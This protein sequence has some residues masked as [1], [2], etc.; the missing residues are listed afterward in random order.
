MHGVQVLACVLIDEQRTRLKP[1]L[2]A[3]KRSMLCKRKEEADVRNSRL[4]RR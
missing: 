4:R 3:C 2:H 1:E